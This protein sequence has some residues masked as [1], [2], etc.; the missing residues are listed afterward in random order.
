M[1]HHAE[2]TGLIKGIQLVQGGPTVSHLLFADDSLLL[3]EA[4]QDSIQVINQIL[5]V[6]EMGSG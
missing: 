1:L 2:R 6:Y 3:F 4:T 5:H